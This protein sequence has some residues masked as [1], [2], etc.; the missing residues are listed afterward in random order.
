[1]EQEII[2][3]IEYIRSLIRNN[4]EESIH[5]DFK[6]AGSLS[7]D[8]KKHREIA[9]DV[10]AF[11]NSDGGII[12]YGV[13]ESDH[14]ASDLSYIDG[15]TYNKEWLENV[16]TSNIQKRINGIEI[17]PIRDGGDINKTIYVVKIPRS[18]NA[19]HMSAGNRYYR[20]FNF[21]SVPMDEFEVRDLFH[22]ANMPKLE[23]AGKKVLRRFIEDDFVEYTFLSSVFNVSNTICSQYKL[24]WYI[25]GN[26]GSCSFLY[27]KITYTVMNDNKIKFSISEKE[28]IYSEEAIDMSSFKITVAK[29][30]HIDFENDTKIEI[31][32]FYRGGEDEIQINLKK[33]IEE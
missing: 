2:Y 31:K 10:S 30:S 9:K 16:I 5:L 28:T 11:A 24:N 26:I 1:M 20:R 4:V 17:I 19:P 21:K 29:G 25:I 22:R 27:D 15:N 18:N 13:T 8:D 6:A 12:I 23:I 3:D 33:L 7:K 32:L 14:K